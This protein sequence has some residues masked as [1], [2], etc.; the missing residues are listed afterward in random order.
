MELCLAPAEPIAVQPALRSLETT[1]YAN[2]PLPTLWFDLGQL[3]SLDLLPTESYDPWTLLE[4]VSDKLDRLVF[5]HWGTTDWPTHS[6][7]LR[8]FTSLTSLQLPPTY[9]NRVLTSSPLAVVGRLR[10]LRV[11]NDDVG[12]SLSVDAHPALE[13][14]TIPDAYSRYGG[15]GGLPPHHPTQAAV[16][17]ICLVVTSFPQRF[18]SLRS[19]GLS[20]NGGISFAHCRV[21]AVPGLVDVSRKLRAAGLQLVDGHSVAWREEW[22]ADGVSVEGVGGG[23]VG[24]GGGEGGDRPR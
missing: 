9:L 2:S 7:V 13:R 11:Y 3:A 16:D 10:D 24:G 19:V 21:R 1:L 5:W 20:D 8:R 18:S 6:H 4:S 22:D 12:I 17:E 23:A 14:V 15:A